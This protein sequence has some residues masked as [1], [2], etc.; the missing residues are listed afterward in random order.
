[1]AQW[2]KELRVGRVV[3]RPK[4]PDEDFLAPFSQ[5]VV[6]LAKSLSEARASAEEEARLRETGE[7]MWTAERLRISIQ[8]RPFGS[9]LVVSNREPHMHVRRGKSIEA[10]VPASGLV[11]ALEP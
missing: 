2:M 9:L 3:P 7:S 8:S 10:L 6:N 5:E 11:T 1:T 4:I